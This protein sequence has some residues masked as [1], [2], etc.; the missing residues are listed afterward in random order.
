M[1]SARTHQWFRTDRL[2][3]PLVAGWALLAS[4]TS[5]Y[6]NDGSTSNDVWCS[7]AGADANSGL[8]PSAPV[9]SLQTLLSRYTLGATNTVF[10]DNG[11]YPLS[12]NLVVGSQ[13][14]GDWSSPLILQGVSGKTVFDR[15]DQVSDSACLE[16]R[17][18]HIDIQGFTFTGARCGLLVDSQYCTSS[19]IRGNI[20]R[21]NSEVGLTVLATNATFGALNIFE[22]LFHDTGDGMRL[23]QPG[24]MYGPGFQVT[25]NTL[26][27][28][29][30]SALVLGGYLGS[31]SI[32]N[33]ILDIGGSA[34]GYAATGDYSLFSADYNNLWVHD[35][36]TVASI[37]QYGTNHVFWSLAHWQRSTQGMYGW[38]RDQHSISR[39]PLFASPANGD[40]H[41]QS[42]GGRWVS[43]GNGGN[44]VADN[45]DSPCLDAADP[46]QG[47]YSEPWP[48]GG[49]L[50]LGSHGGTAEASKSPVGRCLLAMA[51][52][53]GQTPE[54]SQPIHWR[55][56]GQAWTNNTQVRLEYALTLNGDWQEIASTLDAMAGSYDW[57]RPPRKL[58]GG[59]RPL[60]A[61][62][63]TGRQLRRRPGLP[64]IHL[65]RSV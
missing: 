45:L 2:I 31:S 34:V 30:G 43:S 29:T 15:Q 1:N 57:Q 42:T 10:V 55:A 14:G 24:S 54:T 64:S 37:T 26:V 27:V 63:R 62:L 17:A 65:W 60:G 51:P 59:H 8:S 46:S 61:C 41:V 28:T 4:G 16:I 21:N 35:Q 36:G 9:A 39:D 50:N 20:F 22:N 49:C 58:W 11:V 52:D 19:K 44:W 3:F 12:S 33:N 56:V 25:Q 5:Y 23:G 13:H 6:V 38:G 47:A 48:N 18:D 53:L 7:A 40:Y 32:R